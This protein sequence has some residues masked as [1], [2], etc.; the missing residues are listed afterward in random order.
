MLPVE[1]LRQDF[2][3]NAVRKR[4]E[5]IRSPDFL[6]TPYPNF[7]LLLINGLEAYMHKLKAN[8]DTK[9]LLSIVGPPVSGKTALANKLFDVLKPFANSIGQED[10]KLLST[11]QIGNE[12]ES[13]GSIKAIPGMPYDLSSL[14]KVNATAEDRLAGLLSQAGPLIVIQDKLGGTASKHKGV[15]LRQSDREYNDELFEEMYTGQPPYHKI[16]PESIHTITAGIVGTPFFE[17]FMYARLVI[18]LSESLDEVNMKLDA[19]GIPPF[20]NPLE[21]HKAK[22]GALPIQFIA[23]TYSHWNQLLR[24]RT[25]ADE[26]ASLPEYINNEALAV[27]ELLQRDFKKYQ[28][29][30][31]WKYNGARTLGNAIGIR[32]LRDPVSQLPEEAN[33]FLEF[34]AVYNNSPYVDVT[35]IDSNAITLIANELDER[36]QVTELEEVKG[37]ALVPV[38][39]RITDK[40]DMA[41]KN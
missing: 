3:G 12:L 22:G 9:L 33:N 6:D 40:M 23:A 16:N 8:S 37:S 1:V 15:W 39:R 19:F 7:Y 14:Q 5:N 34:A 28:K 18:N 27:A 30:A 24:E 26:L 17:L 38:Y 31:Y 13:D 35:K 32:Q 36:M 29:T 20:K 4:L 11:D 10:P 25:T 21:W 2:E 41:G